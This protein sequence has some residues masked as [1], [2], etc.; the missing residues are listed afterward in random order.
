MKNWWVKLGCFL[1]GYNYNIVNS[2][3]EVAVMKVKQT[4]SALLVVCIIWAFVGYVFT[5]RYLDG[6]IFESIGGSIIACI[7]IVQIERQIILSINPSGVLFAMRILIAVMMAIIGSV[8]I[9]QVIFKADIEKRKISLLDAEVNKIY[10]VKSEELRLQIKSLDSTLL[11]KEG[12]RVSLDAELSRSPTIK[13]YN[14]QTSPLT[15]P[16][17]T[18]DSTG[19][20][21]TVMNVVNAKSTSVSSEPNPKRDLVK[22]LDVQI[23]SIRDIKMKKDEALLVLRSSLE[24]DINSKVGFLDE[25]KIMFSILQESNIALGVWLIWLFILFGLELFILASKMG[26]TSNVYDETLKHQERLFKRKLELLS[27]ESNL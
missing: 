2:S 26:E 10:P 5:N 25:L 7:V 12:Q 22:P 16:V 13:I 4:I 15:V 17:T 11:A 20:T 24:E 6:N 18:T 23:A 9:D 1:A 21:T 3:S 27:E 14:S 19:K 8:I